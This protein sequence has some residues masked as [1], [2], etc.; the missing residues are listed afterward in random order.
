M[1]SGESDRVRRL[2]GGRKRKIDLD[3]ELLGALEELVDEDSRGD[4]MSPLGWTAKSTREVA[5]ALTDSGHEAS[6][7]LVRQF[8][9]RWGFSLQAP[10]RLLRVTGSRIGTASSGISTPG[11]SN[12]LMRAVRR[13]RL[14]PRRRNLSASTPTVARSFSGKGIRSGCWCMTFPTRRF[15]RRSLTGW[16]CKAVCV[17]RFV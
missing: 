3:P 4:P 13:F 14:T 12:I 5:R 11:S 8:L 10:R 6:S 16:S 7:T 17:K 15:P 1:V 2:G 9:G